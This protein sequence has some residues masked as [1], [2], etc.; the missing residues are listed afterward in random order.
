MGGGRWPMS[1]S[2]LLWSIEQ[3]T[4]RI[5][6]YSNLFMANHLSKLHQLL[7]SLH[8]RQ[9]VGRRSIR[10]LE[11]EV[12]KLS[13]CRQYRHLYRMLL[14]VLTK[15]MLVFNIR[16]TNNSAIFWEGLSGYIEGNQNKLTQNTRNVTWAKEL[17]FYFFW[18]FEYCYLNK[19][20]KL[21]EPKS[22]RDLIWVTALHY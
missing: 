10:L 21:S 20:H 19:Y 14:K 15:E 9:V 5:T 16:V 2:A 11:D 1:S 17:S 3:Y 18:S 8:K 4:L 7:I 13:V 12:L 22:Q 6:A